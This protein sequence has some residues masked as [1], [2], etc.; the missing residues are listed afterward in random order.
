MSHHHH[1]GVRCKDRPA[2]RDHVEV[3][4]GWYPDGR[5]RMAIVPV[6]MSK[7]CRFDKRHEEPGCQGCRWQLNDDARDRDEATAGS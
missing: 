4:D 7:S 1:A 6:P 3:Q 5:R 2:F